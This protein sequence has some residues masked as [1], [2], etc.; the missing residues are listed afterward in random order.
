MV[1]A[2][3]IQM[4]WKVYLEL[5]NQAHRHKTLHIEVYLSIT[6]LSEVIQCYSESFSPHRYYPKYTVYAKLSQK[7]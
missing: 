7:S 4:M 3:V 2:T 1:P 5:L 6:L